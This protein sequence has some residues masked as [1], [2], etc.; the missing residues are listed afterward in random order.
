MPNNKIDLVKDGYNITNLQYPEDLGAPDNFANYGGNRVVFFINVQGGGMIARNDKKNESTMDIPK[1]GWKDFAG[2]EVAQTIQTAATYAI[3]GATNTINAAYNLVGQ[4]DAL[5]KSFGA[6]LKLIEPKKRLKTAINLY[7]PNTLVK[8]Y[9]VDWGEASSE[10]MLSS[11]LKAQEI[12]GARDMVKGGAGEGASRIG[13]AVVGYAASKA[14]GGMS[15]VQKSLGIAPGNA[16]AEMLFQGVDFNTFNFDYNFVPKSETEAKKVL[17]IIRTFRHHMLPEYLDE[18]N[19]L[20]IYPSEFDIRYYR[21]TE[22]NQHL[23]KHFT[24][25]LTNM[26]IDYTSNGQFTTFANGMPTHIHVTLSF[27]E[28]TKPTKETSPANGSGA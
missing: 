24:A 3:K 11:D 22:E 25:V 15:Y 4:K 7:V 2:T 28:L 5:D 18:L 17:E 20:Y 19:Y 9:S 10:D 13:R 16:K 8:G 26:Q 12:L 1:G 27:K 14:L 6:S 21:G 23:E